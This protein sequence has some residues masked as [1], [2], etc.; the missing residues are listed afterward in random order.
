LLRKGS[1]VVGTGALCGRLGRRPAACPLTIFASW[2]IAAPEYSRAVPLNHFLS[3]VY[4]A[5]QS[6]VI[7]GAIT[8]TAFV[9]FLVF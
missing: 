4:S 2:L 1:I 3:L 6:K 9:T 5:T 8:S 7:Q